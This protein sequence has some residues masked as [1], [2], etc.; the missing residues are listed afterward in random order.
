MEHRHFKQWANLREHFKKRLYDI[1]K[2]H[3]NPN[4]FYKIN[5]HH[6]YDNAVMV[7]VPGSRGIWSLGITQ[8]LEIRPIEEI[9]INDIGLAEDHP[10]FYPD[11]VF[12]YRKTI[13]RIILITMVM[14]YFKK[15][16]S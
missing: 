12:T 3:G 15:F 2:E 5:L 16:D 1:L 6:M 7:G 8:I 4:S 13:V 14:F 11:I 10:Q 9:S